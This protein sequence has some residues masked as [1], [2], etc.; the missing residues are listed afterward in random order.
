MADQ[1]CEEIHHV[2]EGLD[3]SPCEVEV[4]G[5][6]YGGELR[7]WHRDTT[8]AWFAGVAWARGG[9]RSVSLDRFSDGQVRPA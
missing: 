2:Y 3:R 5:R 4:D 1:P 8:G 7:S 6:W 9:E